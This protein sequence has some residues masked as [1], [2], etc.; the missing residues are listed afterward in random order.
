MN[1]YPS[2]VETDAINDLDPTVKTKAIT[3]YVYD[4]FHTPAEN[5]F[6]RREGIL[7]GISGGAALWAAVQEAQKPEY[8]GKTIVVLLQEC[9]S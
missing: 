6:A 1:Y 5:D 2:V 4:E 7:T 3:A 9:Y 8:E